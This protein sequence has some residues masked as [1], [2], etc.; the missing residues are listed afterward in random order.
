MHQELSPDPT[1]RLHK[2]LV[3]LVRMIGLLHPEHAIPGQMVSLS[4][5]FAL[6]ELDTDAGLSQQDLAERLGLEK[7]SVSRMAAEME[8][9][10]LLVREREPGNRRLYR[11]QL[12][13]RGRDLHRRMGTGFHERYVRWTSAMTS[14][15]LDALLAGLAA[16][17]RAIRD[18][19]RP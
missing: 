8:R 6:H 3:E 7:S 5:L 19:P 17:V 13:D 11:L 12:T 1:E 14:D 18:E 10:G 15:E 16:L 2:L 4:Q 9:R